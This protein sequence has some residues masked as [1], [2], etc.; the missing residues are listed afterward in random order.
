ML[1]CFVVA[2]YD[3]GMPKRG[4]LIS[5]GVRQEDLEKKSTKFLVD[6]GFTVELIVPS[7]T[8]QNKNPDL[9]LEGKIWELKTPIT[10][11]KKT[12]RRRLKQADKQSENIIIDLRFAKISGEI[13]INIIKHEASLLNGVRRLIIIGK[14]EE[15]LRLEK[16]K[17]KIAI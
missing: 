16:K 6:Y 10:G 1:H 4:K 17:G 2:S 5:N 11:S 9:L 15:V 8:A 12:L 7:S 13:A 3:S 14:N